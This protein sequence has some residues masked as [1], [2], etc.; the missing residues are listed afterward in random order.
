MGKGVEEN[1]QVANRRA[2]YQRPRSLLL[3]TNHA[4]LNK[5][6]YSGWRTPASRFQAQCL[7]RS[8]KNDIVGA[9]GAQHGTRHG[10]RGLQRQRTIGGDSVMSR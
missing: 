9:S 7:G 8:C 3:V 2:K 1:R 10:A 5:G 4:V 6:S